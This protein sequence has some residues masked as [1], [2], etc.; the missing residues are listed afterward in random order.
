MI[1]CTAVSLP[2]EKLYKKPKSP[3]RIAG[4]GCNVAKSKE[5]N[6]FSTLTR[7]Q[8]HLQ[9]AHTL[10]ERPAAVAAAERAAAA[11]AEATIIAATAAEVEAAAAAIKEAM[12]QLPLL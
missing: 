3:R 12:N 8:L 5:I 2:V 11:A 1:P 6:P 4:K 9:K 10:C 7:I